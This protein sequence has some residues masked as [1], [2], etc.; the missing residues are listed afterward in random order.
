MDQNVNTKFLYVFQEEIFAIAMVTLQDKTIIELYESEE[1]NFERTAYTWNKDFENAFL[2]YKDLVKII[3]EYQPEDLIFASDL[4]FKDICSL[5]N[6][7]EY[8]DWESSWNS[9]CN[10]IKEYIKTTK[11]V[12]LQISELKEIMEK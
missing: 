3:E 9:C 6:N 2:E 11:L 7:E 1:C 12:L 8:F 5:I 10:M 4:R